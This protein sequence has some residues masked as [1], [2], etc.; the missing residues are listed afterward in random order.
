VYLIL[1]VANTLK[2][3]KRRFE[4]NQNDCTFTVMSLLPTLSEQIFDDM[5]VEELW[6][7]LQQLRREQKQKQEQL[8]QKEIEEAEAKAKEEEALKAQEQVTEEEVNVSESATEIQ[9]DTETNVTAAPDENNGAEEI[10]EESVQSNPEIIKEEPE[11]REKEKSPN[12]LDQ[13]PTHLA[14]AVNENVIDSSIGSL[15]NSTLSEGSEISNSQNL[16][17]S[18]EDKAAEQK[19]KYALWEEIKVKSKIFFFFNG[20]MVRYT[21][22]AIM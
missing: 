18:Q 13:K 4:Q 21:K 9:K 19:S 5:A 20:I 3:L 10:K 12:A 16:S 1:G 7:K 11:S 2:S 17:A 22:H 15:A 14:A 8:K 6:T